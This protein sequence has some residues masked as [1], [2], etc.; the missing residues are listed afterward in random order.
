[1][2]R[3]RF[4]DGT[5]GRPLGDDED[6]DVGAYA[7]EVEVEDRWDDMSPAE[8]KAAAAGASQGRWVS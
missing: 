5:T 3:A 6:L 2:S 4:E 8:Q 1:V 7:A